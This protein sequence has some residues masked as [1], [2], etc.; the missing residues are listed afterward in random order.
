MDI[1]A[2]GYLVVTSTK[3]G[4]WATYGQEVL[5]L[6]AGEGVPEGGLLLRADERPYR[7]AVLPGDVDGMQ[8]IGWEVPTVQALETAAAELDAAGVVVEHDHGKLAPQRRVT[9]VFS[10]VPPGGGVRH[11]VFYGPEI[12]YTPFTS[13]AAVSGFVTGDLGLGHVVL[14]AADLE[15]AT[16]F[17]V[18][19]MGF[20][21]SDTMT[22]PGT[23]V[24]FMHCNARHHSLALAQVP[25][26]YAGPAVNHIMLEVNNVDDVGYAL[27]RIADHGVRLRES[28]GRHTND[29]MLSFY[30]ATP[31]GFSIEF[32]W[33]A[34]LVDDAKWTVSETSR[35]SY[36]GHRRV[37]KPAPDAVR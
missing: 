28:L 29:E 13:P 2:L 12:D 16:S 20:R 7:I 14:T 34:R 4:E 11:E 21:I 8:A 22:L 3:V 17:Y 6:M 19:T 36:W 37:P 31:G 24:V 15:A 26:G 35:G 27:D 30:A 5:G 1:R 23:R 32:G 18:D 9:G 25:D 33:G 10:F